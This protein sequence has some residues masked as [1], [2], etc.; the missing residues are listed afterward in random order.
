M[1]FSPFYYCGI[2]VEEKGTPDTL[3]FGE[4]QSRLCTLLA[5]FVR[6]SHAQTLCLWGEE[7]TYNHVELDYGGP[8]RLKTKGNSPFIGKYSFYW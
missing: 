4:V 5:E 7:M 2:E 1:N 6:P 8:V 3:N